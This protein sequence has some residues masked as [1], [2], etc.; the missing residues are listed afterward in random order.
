MQRRVHALFALLLLLMLATPGAATW[1]ADPADALIAQGVKLL[2]AGHT[3]QAIAVFA[4][5]VQASPHNPVA[6]NNLAY[7]LEEKG[8][9]DKALAE[10][11]AAVKLKPDYKDARDNLAHAV[12]SKAR[13][14]SNHGETDAALGMLGKV[15]TEMPDAAEA[16]YTT[17][18]ILKDAGRDS[19]ALNAWQHAAELKPNSGITHYVAAS[20]R[21][22]AKDFTTA[23]DELKKALQLTPKN[24]YAHNLMGMALA[25]QR[26]FPAALSEF[27]AA[28]KIEPGY[29]NAWI[30]IGEVANAMGQPQQALD[31]FQHAAKANPHNCAAA[32][33]IAQV[34]YRS[35]DF[36]HARDMAS[37]AVELCPQSSDAQLQLGLACMRLSHY[38]ESL[39]HLT[40]GKELNPR[41][42]QCSYALCVLY[43]AAGQRASALHELEDLKKTNVEPAMVA[44]AQ[45][46][47]NS[48]PDHGVASPSPG[49]PNSPTPSPAAS[50]DPG[51]VAMRP[52][53]KD[54][55]TLDIPKSWYEWQ[56]TGDENQQYALETRSK[57]GTVLFLYRRKP[58]PGG[59]SLKQ[60]ADYVADESSKL[61]YKA[62]EQVEHPF[63]GKPGWR[64]MFLGSG[65]EQVYLYVTLEGGFAYAMR[66]HVKQPDDLSTF[67]RIAASAQFS[68]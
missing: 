42:W 67:E 3:D 4:R 32:L 30:N 5:A 23:I 61:G 16:W 13:Q 62:A 10:Y 55:I 17:G 45:G 27:Q 14:L 37:K 12:C 31:A 53:A 56:L 57:T 18:V 21:Y 38:K 34:L 2:Q 28:V 33:K 64:Y 65:G 9:L 15:T 63:G 47:I 20:V 24:V 26:Q 44:K 60:V 43:A 58:V 29:A 40:K 49:L 66:G 59:A 8:D 7:A 35:G 22:E 54:G 48:M 25:Q 1:A 51:A 46:F 39:E 19:E 41:D 68:K 6:H 36:S 52:V 11:Y 50:A